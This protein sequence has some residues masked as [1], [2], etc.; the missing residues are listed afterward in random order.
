MKR[1]L[2]GVLGC[3]GALGS[4]A[5]NVL[6]QT[7]TI[8]GGQRRQ[9]AGMKDDSNF[10]WAKVDL[11]KEEE[12]A[13]FCKECDVILNCAGPSYL[14]G[15]R[16]AVAAARE[17]AFY[18]DTFGASLIED[19]LLKKGLEKESVFIIAAGSFPGLSGILPR[20]LAGQ[21][22]DSAVSMYSFAG[23][24]EHCSPCAG[25]DLLLSSVS[26]YGTPGAYIKNGSIVRALDE[27]YEK[28]YIPFLKEEV[29]QQKFLNDET[30]KLASLLQ[31][32]EACWYNMSVDKTVNDAIFNSS[33]RLSM[34]RSEQA[35]QETI[36]E[37]C[38]AAAMALCGKQPWY[39][40]TTELQGEKRGELIRKRCILRSK[41]SYELSGVVAAAAVETLLKRKM[42][43]GI[44]WACEVLDPV[45]TVEMLFSAKAAASIDIVDIP[46]VR[47]ND[48]QGQMEEGKL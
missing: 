46:P 11:Y 10:Q 19:S 25:L 47:E 30:V 37:L 6:K 4:A 23:G 27:H 33:A 12:L 14:V 48:V 38:A 20:W 39:V 22:F 43:P 8:R 21:G 13:A 44:Y 5:C 40:M 36:G 17:N 1:P 15:D 7:Y 42:E 3:G 18:I 31:L 16:V 28:V 35:L 26:N 24:R 29:Y 9:P 45:E 2:I 34:D 41:S 32:K